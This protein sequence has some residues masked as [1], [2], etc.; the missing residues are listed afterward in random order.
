M[1]LVPDRPP[2]S[3]ELDPS[4]LGDA[5]TPARIVAVAAAITASS[6]AS[7][8]QRVVASLGDHASRWLVAKR[9]ASVTGRTPGDTGLP[10]RVA[11]LNRAR[12]ELGALAGVLATPDRGLAA[13][14]LQAVGRLAE[15]ELCATSSELVPNDLVGRVLVEQGRTQLARAS[16]LQYAGKGD[17]AFAIATNV[18]AQLPAEAAPQLRAEVLFVQARAREQ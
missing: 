5:W 17:E 4:A 1:Q 6:D 8:G 12:R 14:A 10:R 2:T 7:S 18:L 3:C 11:C 13:T 15:P 9:E 16:A